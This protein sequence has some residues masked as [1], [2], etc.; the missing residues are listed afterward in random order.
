MK[1]PVEDVIAGIG[2]AALTGAAII[3]GQW[4]MQHHILCRS[5]F[6]PG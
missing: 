6:E 3:T 4:P 1:V 2:A 5:R